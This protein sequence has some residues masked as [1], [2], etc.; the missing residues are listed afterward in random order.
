MLLKFSFFE[1]VNSLSVVCLSCVGYN[2][3][4]NKGVRLLLK[5]TYFIYENTRIVGINHA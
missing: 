5:V 4:K 2:I 3:A 1:Q